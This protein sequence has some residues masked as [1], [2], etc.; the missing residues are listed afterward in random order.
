MLTVS[1]A[2]KILNSGK[3]KY[4][5]DEVEQILKLIKFWT[6]LNINDFLKIK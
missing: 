5:R 1:D 4:T 6:T 3:N 2:E